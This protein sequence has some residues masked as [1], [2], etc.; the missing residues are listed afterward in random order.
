MISRHGY[1]EMVADGILVEEVI[2]GLKGA[3][4][5]EDYP[6]YPKG[7]SVLVLQK[8]GRGEPIHV[9]WGI[10]KGARSPAVVVTA[11]RPDPAQWADDFARRKV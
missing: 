8:D 9:V 11:Y 7:S 5:I 2:D 1:Y 10:P 4:M 6:N 3:K